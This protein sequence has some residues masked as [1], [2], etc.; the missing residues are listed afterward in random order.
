MEYQNRIN[1]LLEA[2]SYLGRKAAGNTWERM[3][4]QIRRKGID[5]SPTF[6]STMESMKVV[7]E[8]LDQ[9]CASTDVLSL[10]LNLEGFSHNT[11]GSAS[12]AFFLL[13]GFLETHDGDFYKLVHRSQE[14]SMAQRAYHIALALDMQEECDPDH[15]E[16]D[17]FMRMVL[18]LSIPDAG[19]VAIMET[20][21]NFPQLM[22]QLAQP[23]TQILSVI[24][25][26]RQTLQQLCDV[27]QEKMT[28]VGCAAYLADNSSF[29]PAENI[30][31]ILRPFVFGLDTDLTTD[32][33]IDEV[34]MYSGILRQELL[35]MLSTLRSSRDSLFDAF[36]LLGDKTRFELVCYLSDHSAYGQ[37]LSQRFDLS[38]NTI[39]HHM[40]K[41]S[42]CGLVR[43][44]A[45]GNRVYYTLNRERIRTLLAFQEELLAG[46]VDTALNKDNQ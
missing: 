10:F 30:H 32:C 45:D 13:Y 3:E 5:P 21:Q 43:C 15:M 39:H 33:S 1:P 4:E 37:E 40:S 12:R 25:Q 19:K 26:Q 28:A 27:L 22:A 38:R 44:T 23:M 46:G 18:S 20:Y 9:I 36:R 14:M 24:E 35:D 2:I 11:I 6:L 8:H 42:Q 17:S 7:T 16:P 41:L 34:C 31:Y 29:T